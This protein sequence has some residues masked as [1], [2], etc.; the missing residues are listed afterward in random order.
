MK[1]GRQILLSVLFCLVFA[2]PSKSF[3]ILAHEAIIDAEWLEHIRPLLL[4]KYPHVTE[5]QL[6]SAHAYAYGGSLV[7]DMGYMPMGSPYFTNLLHYVRSGDLVVTLVNEAHNL[8]EYAFALGAISHYLADKY[9]HSLATNVSVAIAHPDL[10]KKF[11][12]VVTYDED[13]TSHSNMEFAYDIIQTVKGNYASTAYHNFIGFSI[14]T[15]VLK[16]AFAITYGQDLD[17]VFPNFQSAISIFRWGVR[18]LFPELARVAWKSDKAGIQQS[19]AGIKRE[20]FCY[21][22]PKAAFDKKY[23]TAYEH[24]GFTTRSI[25]FVIEALPKVGPLKKLDFK[26]PGLACEQLYLKS[27]DTILIAYDTILQKAANGQLALEN[28]DFDTGHSSVFNEY[29]L[30]DKT[31]TDWLSALQKEQFTNVDMPIQRNIASFYQGTNVDNSLLSADTRKLIAGALAPSKTLAA[32][33][34]KIIK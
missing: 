31:Y 23:G 22:M 5:T 33:Q 7:A 24:T 20:T 4:K 13:H 27:I 26:Y 16:R 6:D 15:P 12:N 8:N 3:S 17:K 2:A 18:N 25:V 28:I 32:T 19:F 9:G 14:A 10:Q 21:K 11:G 30:A 34:V 29:A 1:R